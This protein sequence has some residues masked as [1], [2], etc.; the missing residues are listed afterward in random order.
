MAIVGLYGALVE[1][2]AAKNIDKMGKTISKI[3]KTMLLIVGVIKLFS[4]LSPD[5]V[6][7]G[8]EFAGV[9][10]GFVIVL[11][12]IS[13]LAGDNIDSLGKTIKSIVVSMGLMIGVVKLAGQLSPDDMINGVKFAGAFWHLLS[14]WN[15]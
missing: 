13:Y 10:T 11:A 9:F 6:D 8:L 3:G 12:A 5:E 4:M 1:G 14:V 7:K 2:E 15:L